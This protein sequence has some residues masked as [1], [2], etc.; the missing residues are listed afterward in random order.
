[1][2]AVP[3]TQRSDLTISLEPPQGGGPKKK[4]KK[5]K[6]KKELI[7]SLKKLHKII[8]KIF[9]DMCIFMGYSYTRFFVALSH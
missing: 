5:K 2:L 7:F 4:K 9:I 6:K 3:N 8:Y 1:M